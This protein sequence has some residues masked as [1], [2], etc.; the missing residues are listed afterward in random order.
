MVPESWG[1]IWIYNHVSRLRDKYT[2]W[3]E[4]ACPTESV[5]RE[6]WAVFCPCSNCLLMPCPWLR[7]SDLPVLLWIGPAPQ[8]SPWTPV[9]LSP[10]LQH[11]WD[12][13]ATFLFL[14]LWH[15]LSFPHRAVHADQEVS[16]P[17][18]FWGWLLF[19]IEVSVP[20]S[21]PQRGFLRPSV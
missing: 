20:L 3:W 8:P 4:W 19:V 13:V 21:T 17:K 2:L 11:T 12:T 6:C 9:L 18:S 5:P 16:T 7:P 10:A 14:K 1:L 15:S